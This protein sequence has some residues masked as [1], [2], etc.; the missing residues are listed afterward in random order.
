[1]MKKRFGWFLVC[2]VLLCS[3]AHAQTLLVDFTGLSNADFF[4]GPFEPIITSNAAD[5]A[6]ADPNVDPLAS[7]NQ[8]NVNVFNAIGV[9]PSNTPVSGI[10]VSANLDVNLSIAGAPQPVNGFRQGT[11]CK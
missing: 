8:V 5:F 11:I 4:G 1:M 10:G 2:S 9:F 6:V 7:V 3:V